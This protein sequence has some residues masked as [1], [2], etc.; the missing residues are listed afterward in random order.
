MFHRVGYALATEPH[1]AAVAQT[2]EKL[3][4][5]TRWH[6]ILPRLPLLRRF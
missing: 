3:G 2:L 1:F 5:G 4:A 6:V